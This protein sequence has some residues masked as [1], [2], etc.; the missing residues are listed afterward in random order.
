MDEAEQRQAWLIEYQVCQQSIR[1]HSSRFWVIVGIF[2]GVNTA[3]LGWASG[4]LMSNTPAVCAHQSNPTVYPGIVLGAGMITSL[5]FLLGWINRVNWFLRVIYYRMQAIE[6][7]LGMRNNLI[8]NRLDK[9]REKGIRLFQGRDICSHARSLPM[10]TET[11]SFKGIIIVL[12]VLWIL[13]IIFSVVE[14]SG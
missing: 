5:G 1:S 13:I 2:I 9:T 10:L 14:K 6:R 7:K 12:I 11:K 4:N 8:I 3:L